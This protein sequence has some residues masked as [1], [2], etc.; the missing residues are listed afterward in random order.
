MLEDSYQ[1]CRPKLR[2]RDGLH[3]TFGDSRLE[4]LWMTPKFSKNVC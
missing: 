1:W 4:N 3:Q 2:D